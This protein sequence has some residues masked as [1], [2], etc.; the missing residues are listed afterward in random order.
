MAIRTISL[1]LMLGLL[2]S[3]SPSY[4]SQERLLDAS[5]ED[6]LQIRKQWAATRHKIKKHQLAV[7]VERFELESILKADYRYE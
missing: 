5:A 3:T 4:A 1:A 7:F 6:T 2:L